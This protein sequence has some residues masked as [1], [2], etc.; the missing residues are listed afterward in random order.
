MLQEG[1]QSFFT[2][3]NQSIEP[4]SPT[5]VNLVHAYSGA[6]RQMAL[7]NVSA[8]DAEYRHHGNRFLF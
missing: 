5:R 3:A 7:L 6:C 1:K 8:T 4:I 2:K